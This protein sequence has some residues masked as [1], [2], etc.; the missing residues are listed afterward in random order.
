MNSNQVKKLKESPDG[1]QF[2][3]VAGPTEPLEEVWVQTDAMP[4]R[5]KAR[6]AGETADIKLT[7]SIISKMQCS[8]CS[9][10]GVGERYQ[11]LRK[12]DSIRKMS[13]IEAFTDK[14]SS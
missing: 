6:Q 14:P 10:T 2:Y 5:V 3:D 13:S 7:E 9:K 1:L 11:I 8:T 4:A 12:T